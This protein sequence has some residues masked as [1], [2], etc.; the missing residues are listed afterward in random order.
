MGTIAEN[1][2][3]VAFRNCP[4]RI[5]LTGEKKIT[6]MYLGLFLFTVSKTLLKCVVDEC[7]SFFLV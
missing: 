7:P 1:T 4:T 3:K 2:S 5:A 6:F